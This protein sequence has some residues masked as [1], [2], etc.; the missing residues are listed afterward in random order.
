MKSRSDFGEEGSRKGEKSGILTDEG[1]YGVW[2]QETKPVEMLLWS[3]C[4]ET[5]RVIKSGEI[6]RRDSITR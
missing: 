2:R 5:V 4:R 1:E 6:H 3:G